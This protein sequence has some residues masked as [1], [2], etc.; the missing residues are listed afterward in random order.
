MSDQQTDLQTQPEQV[1][2]EPTPDLAQPAAELT[3]PPEA[4]ATDAA[5]GQPVTAEGRPAAPAPDFPR[6]PVPSVVPQKNAIDDPSSLA[7]YDRAF[8]QAQKY[9]QNYLPPDAVAALQQQAF[10]PESFAHALN[11]AAIAYRDPERAHRDAQLEQQAR[12]GAQQELMR[13]HGQ[14]TSETRELIHRLGSERMAEIRAEGAA[15]REQAAG[16][17]KDRAEQ[18]KG[19]YARAWSKT[20]QPVDLSRWS[21]IF[22]HPDKYGPEAYAKAYG[23]A[24]ALIQESAAKDQEY[25]ALK[26]AAIQGKN[27]ELL[28]SWLQRNPQYRN[29]PGAQ[30]AVAEAMKNREQET[31]WKQKMQQERLRLV[32]QRSRIMEEAAQRRQSISK[33]MDLAYSR[34]MV[35]TSQAHL[36]AARSAYNMAVI[37]ATA[38]ETRDPHGDHSAAAEAVANAKADLDAA[39]SDYQGWYENHEELTRKTLTPNATPAAPPQNLADGAIAFLQ[40]RASVLTDASLTP[41]AGSP[42]A[43]FESGNGAFETDPMEQLQLL[44]MSNDPSAQALVTNI[45]SK[46]YSDMVTAYAG[47][48]LK[49]G[50]V[51]HALAMAWTQAAAA[52]AQ[53]ARA[54]GLAQSALTQQ[55]YQTLPSASALPSAPPAQ[56]A[57]Q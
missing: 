53:R 33:N 34:Q 28:D 30:A 11:R 56:G 38:E 12:L 8:Q 20:G 39:N 7:W 27:P 13:L 49:D 32:E 10:G 4:V 26:A 55:P 52:A 45:Y 46:A 51:R 2:V 40:K 15:Q 19:L 48:G 5:S 21:D 6:G 41:A 1:P 43:T 23:E 18:L 17:R 14:E 47:R 50:D 35:Q 36:S 9:S 24:S 3:L 16:E 44:A 29:D 54:A 42:L 37:A 25:D 22:L 31:A 57:A